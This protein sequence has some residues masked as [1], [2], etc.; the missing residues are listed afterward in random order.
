MNIR[1]LIWTAILFTAL[2]AKKTEASEEKDQKKPNILFIAIDDMNDW[3]GFLGG[4]PQ[5][6]TP[7]MDHLADAGI[8]FTNAHC[9]AP[10]C[11]PSRNAI[12]YGVEPYQS[13]LYPFY[14]HEIHQDLHERYVSLPRLFKENG[15]AT[16]GV[17]KVHHG[18]KGNPIEWTGYNQ[19]IHGEKEFKEGAGYQ[20]G[21]S[22]KHSFRPTV[23]PLQEHADY[24]R[25]SYGVEMLSRDHDRPF[26]LAVGFVKPHLPFDAPQRFFDALPDSIKPPAIKENDLN[27]IGREGR[28]MCRRGDDRR[29]RRDNAWEDVRRAYLACISWTDY[30]VGRLLKALK[31]SPYASNT[32]VVLWSDHGFHLGEKHSFKK[33]TLWEEAT[34]VPFIIRDMRNQNPEKGRQCDQPVSLIDIYRTLTDMTGLQTPEYV[35]GNSLVPQLKEPSRIIA[36]PAVTSWGRGNIALRTENWR[37][38]RYYDGAEE[39]YW[40]DKDPYEWNNL[41]DDPGFKGRKLEMSRHLPESIAPLSNK[42][43]VNRWSVY[44]ADKEAFDKK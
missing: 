34:R 18:S 25:A 12:M 43:L 35:D 22:W 3:T 32:I 5:A 30:N 14:D 6:L 42:D 16:Y 24:Q 1:R 37:Y 41:I 2:W 40:H 11:A 10:G 33:F 9:P 7:N 21:N 38:I 36:D 19:D 13:G 17:G 29:F 31:Q 20:V 15:Y 28:S 4:H 44:G 39:L 27:D 23:N 26:F 8:N